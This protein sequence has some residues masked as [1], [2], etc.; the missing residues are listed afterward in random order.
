MDTVIIDSLMV[1]ADTAAVVADTCCA[2]VDEIT[3]VPDP[4][5]EGV[6]SWTNFFVQ[7][8]GELTIAA[9]AFLKVI[10]NLTPTDRDNAVFAWVDTMIDYIIPDR[11]KA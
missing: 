4:E 9:L 8:W 10:V 7:N 11:K 2:T 6:F 3:P 1:I 5:V